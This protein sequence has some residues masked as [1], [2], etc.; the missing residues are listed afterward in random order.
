MNEKWPF[1]KESLHYLEK[2]EKK[3]R[4]A[5]LLLNEEFYEDAVSRAYY[6]VFHAIVALLRFKEVDL[7]RHK[8]TF[9]LNQFRIQYIDTQILA[10]DLF[11]KILNIRGIR[12]HADYSINTVI[13]EIEAE[14]IVNDAQIVVDTIKEYLE[15]MQD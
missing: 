11:S 12:E 9:I 8:H 5:T 10:S 6:A 7:S 13:E 3:L 14:R 15:Q 4:S 1:K 2:A